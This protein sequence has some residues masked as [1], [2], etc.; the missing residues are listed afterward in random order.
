QLGMNEKRDRL[1]RL[2]ATE[3]EIKGALLRD[4]AERHRKEPVRVLVEKAEGG[5][6]FG[7]SE[8]YVE[9]SFP[10][11]E[12]DMGQVRDVRLLDVSGDRCVGKTK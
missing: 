8:H 5:F 1:R 6:A 7:H 4:Y 10:G 3:A 11:G 12:D 9:V 2:S